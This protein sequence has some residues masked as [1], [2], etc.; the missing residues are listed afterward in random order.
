MGRLLQ[1]PLP[2]QRERVRALARTGAA[3]EAIAPQVGV[4][5]KRLRKYFRHDLELGRAEGSQQVLDN[6]HETATSGS[7]TTAS[8]FWLKAKCGWRDTGSP[9]AAAPVPISFVIGWSGL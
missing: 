8:M 4:P 6:F 2:E 3:D 9:T 5:L 1:L 7:N